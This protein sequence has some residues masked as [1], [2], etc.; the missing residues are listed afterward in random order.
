MKYVKIV[1]IVALIVVIALS[2][3]VTKQQS[4]SGCSITTKCSPEARE[5][6]VNKF[7][8]ANSIEDLLMVIDAF[9]CTRTYIP[10][11]YYDVVQTFDIDDFIANDCNGLCFDWSCF[12]AIVVR[13]VSKIKGWD[14][15][16]LVA[17][18]KSTVG[19]DAHA[20]NFILVD[21][22][23][24]FLDTTNDNTR[25]KNCKRPIGLVDIGSMSKEEYALKNLNYQ[26]WQY[27]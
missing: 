6:I 18:A 15:T 2:V 16:P 1:S 4:E 11:Q 25:Y 22:K 19:E 14:V 8:D 9:I 27:H 7:G 3:I 17:E 21:G 10:K 12:T 23:T 26:I 20:F 24:Y 13:E 5:F